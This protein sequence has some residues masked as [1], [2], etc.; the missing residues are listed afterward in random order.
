LRVISATRVKLR[1][2]AGIMVTPEPPQRCHQ[3]TAEAPT[4][5]WR[6]PGITAS[7]ADDTA[8]QILVALLF[9]GKVLNSLRLSRLVAL[10]MHRISPA[11]SI[12]Q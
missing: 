9:R 12:L 4:E 10:R 3:A 7:P 11:A 5:Q 6:R 1:I 2:R 8:L